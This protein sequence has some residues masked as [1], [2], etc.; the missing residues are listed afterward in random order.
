MDRAEVTLAQF[1]TR[2]TW[3][4][5]AIELD[6]RRRGLG[7]W[8]WRWRRRRRCR[9]RIARNRTAILQDGEASGVAFP[10]KPLRIEALG[11]AARTVHPGAIA[12][13]VS[14][15]IVGLAPDE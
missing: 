14:R 5:D 12:V 1:P 13:G 7:G 11:Q 15:P 6:Q 8:S 3:K 2:L 9:P 4:R 10:W